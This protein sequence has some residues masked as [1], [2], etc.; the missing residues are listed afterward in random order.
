MLIRSDHKNLSYFKSARKIT[1][2]QARWMESL[3]EFDFEL[4]HIPGSTNTVA[5]L[6]SR[7]SDHNKGVYINNSI[8]ILPDHLFTAYVT[9]E[10]S[11]VCK[12]Y[13]VDD[14]ETRR[15]ILREVHDTPVGGHPGISNTWHLI[16]RN[17]EGPGLH[18]FVEQY[19]KGCA[20]C[21]EAKPRTTLKCTPLQPFDTPVSQGPFQYVSMDLI[22]DLPKSGK[23]D[24]IL[25]IV[26]QG[27][28]KA[29]K[30]IPCNKSIDGEGT[31]ILYFK[32][33]FPWFGIPK[34]IIS[35]RDPRFTSHFAEAVCKAT[36][37]QQNLSTAFHPRTDGQT[38]RMNQWVETY[39]R[40][41]VNNCQN[42]WSALLPLA[43]FAHNSWKHE[44]TKYSPHELITGNVPSAKLMPLDDSTPTVEARLK[45]LS[46]ACSDAQQSL[47]KRSKNNKEPRTLQVNQKVWL[48]ARNLKANVPSKKLAPRCYRPFQITEKVSAVAYR[49]KLPNHFK[50]HDVFHINLLMPYHQ[51]Q[52]Y[53]EA[54]T[55]P[56]PDLIE[57][58][59]EYEVEEIVSDRR[60]GRSR[61]HQYLI[62]WKG[63]PPSENSWVN[64]KDMHAPELVKEFHKLQSRSTVA[65]STYKRTTEVN[66]R[67][68]QLTTADT[69]LHSSNNR[70]LHTNLP[71]HPS[72]RP[73]R[74]IP[75]SI[76]TG[77]PAFLTQKFQKPFTLSLLSCTT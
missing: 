50:I 71:S 51:N 59:E 9:R 26:D 8:Q 31:A 11:A 60:H 28:S 17:Y 32:H 54:Y 20:K 61:S 22:T 37:I 58:E 75:Q 76:C 48:D 77:T 13:L 41:F 63:Y 1:P 18:K 4:K 29:A 6:L 72:Q 5:D 65:S 45:E 47:E 64:A 16:N 62:K 25:T 34:R 49:L 56:P 30:F 44:K 46:R 15:K 35:D 19:I 43:E 7:R 24:A 40:S 55:Q 69:C 2:R 74:S 36:G 38:E 10:L 70:S 23:Y 53:G 27:C 3:E 52:T 66:K 73:L 67:P 21:Q 14:D 57:G 68:H 33:L 12:L 42:N 39:L